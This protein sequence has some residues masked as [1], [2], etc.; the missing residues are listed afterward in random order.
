MGIQTSSGVSREEVHRLVEIFYQHEFKT[1]YINSIDG[2][3]FI[4]PFGIFVSLGLTTSMST[5]DNIKSILEENGYT[6]K[7]A[8]ISSKKVGS[9][10][11]NVLTKN[12]NPSQ[13]RV[14]GDDCTFGKEEAEAELKRLESNLSVDV[15]LDTLAKLSP[16]VSSLRKLIEKLSSTNGWEDHLIRVD[17]DGEYSIFH[18]NVNYKKDGDLEYRV[19]IYVIKKYM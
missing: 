8:E 4:K 17:S 3:E 1:F 10:Y 12:D 2:K 14:I 5:L 9:Q 13:Y 18:K 15:D 16:R 19:G 6:V 11:L 7:I